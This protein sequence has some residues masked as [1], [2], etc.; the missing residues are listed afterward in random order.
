MSV[1]L[2]D[3]DLVKM[4][5]SGMTTLEM[6]RQT[7]IGCRTLRNRMKA[8]GIKPKKR[9]RGGVVKTQ[10]DADI[11]SLWKSGFS[12]NDIADELHISFQTVR[13]RQCS[14]G[15]TPNN[16][17]IDRGRISALWGAGWSL[18]AIAEDVRC[19]MHQLL[20]EMAR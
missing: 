8:L 11:I 2:N 14:L 19:P 12:T 7:G 1:D 3:S 10:H 5:E 16:P 4:C 13:D 15:L 17:Q 6:Q 9:K 20:K 18:E